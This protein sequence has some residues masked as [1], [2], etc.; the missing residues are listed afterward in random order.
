M[1]IQKVFTLAEKWNLSGSYFE[2]CNC[3]VG[4]PCIFLSDPTEEVCT[5]L[6]AW[7]IEKG[8]FGD[9]ELDGLNAVLAVHSPGNMSKVKW[10]A[11]LYLD[12]KAS[13]PQKDALTK[14]FGGQA[15]GVPGALG[16]MIGEVLGVKSVPIEFTVDGKKRSLRIP[17]VAEAEIEAIQGHEGTDA[18]ISSAPLIAVPGESVVVAKSKRLNFRDYGLAWAVSDKNGFY[19][20][21]TYKGP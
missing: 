6:A 11:A 1:C 4:C 21:F 15:G 18:K 3:Q 14:I 5:L 17:E 20:P 8:Q 12:A 13:S 2:A 7:H 16:S 10:R 19:S 9:L